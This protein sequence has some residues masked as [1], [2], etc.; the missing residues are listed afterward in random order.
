MRFVAFMVVFLALAATSL[1]S[2]DDLVESY[3]FNNGS[4]NV[5][6]VSDFM[7]DVDNNSVNDTPGS[8]YG[9]KLA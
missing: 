8:M 7:V 6:A 1:A 2:V 3:N 4:V 5:T 9:R